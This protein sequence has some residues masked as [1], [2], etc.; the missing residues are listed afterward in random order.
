MEQGWSRREAE[1]DASCCESN[2]MDTRRVSA[3]VAQQKGATQG[4]DRGKRLTLRSSVLQLGRDLGARICGCA[5]GRV[6]R[7]RRTGIGYSHKMNNKR[8]CG[9]ARRKMHVL[10]EL[11]GWRRGGLQGLVG[12][13]G[14]ESQSRAKGGQRAAGR[15][16]K[17]HTNE[18]RRDKEV[19]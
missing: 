16:S 18:G 1:G 9:E 19:L 15:E 5:D 6:T 4:Q 10:G 12:G 17:K 2:Q 3:G 13:M 14:S 11:L 8:G 7:T